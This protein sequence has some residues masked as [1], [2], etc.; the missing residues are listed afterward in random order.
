VVIRVLLADD[1]P[2]VRAGLRQILADAPD[3]AVVGEAADGPAVVERVAATHPDVVV[4]D[5]A[6]PGAPFVG[7]LRTL[8]RAY[9]RVAV[10]VLSVHPEDQ[11][12]VRAFRSGAAGYLTK[13]RSPELL[14]AA[15]R[16]VAQGGRSVP[17]AIA[18]RLVTA[19][20]PGGATELHETLSEREYE[21]LCL[22]GSGKTVKDVA[23]HLDLSPKTVSTF[24]ARILHK[25]GLR[26][27][28]DLIRY[29]LKHE[30]A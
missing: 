8:K 10:L 29:A 30:L 19:H 17:D 25:M 23:A 28:A 5:V 20:A 2:V 24:R 7:L 16:K 22:L 18:E 4:L 9:P 1:H 6:M 14:V 3:I 26:T 12:A 21:V 27:S 13:E 15:I 11:Y